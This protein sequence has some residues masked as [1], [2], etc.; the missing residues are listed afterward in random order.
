VISESKLVT[1]TVEEIEA[2]L[3]CAP[4]RGFAVPAKRWL[5]IQAKLHE[6]LAR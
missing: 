3:L 5:A 4:L 1:L 6:A 2:L